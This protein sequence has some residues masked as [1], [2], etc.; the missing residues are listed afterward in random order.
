MEQF[1]LRGAC[2]SYLVTTFL[3]TFATVSGYAEGGINSWIKP[4]S[5]NWDDPAG[6]SQGAL[7]NSSQ[8][9]LITNSGWKAVAINPSTPTDSRTV[10]SIGIAGAWDTRN[11]LL[12]NYFGTDY[13]LTVLNGLTLQ[14]NAQIVNFNSGLIVQGGTITITNSQ[15]IQD[16][17]F[18][19]TTNSTMY[20]Q[21]AEYDLTNGVFEGGQVLLGFPVS[22][23]FNQYGGTAVITNL[24]FGQGSAYAGGH[25]ALYGGELFLPNGLRLLGGNNAY[26]SYFQAG[27]T[28]RTTSVY[29]EP[30]LLGSVPGFTLNGGLLS[31]QDVNMVGDDFGAIYIEQ[32]G[33]THSVSNALNI[34][35]GTSH[36]LPRPSAYHLNGGTLSVNLLNLD[37]HPGDAWFIQSNGTTVAQKVLANA[38][39]DWAYA[40]D[41]LLSGGTLT[42][43][44]LVASSGVNNIHQYGGSLVVSDTLAWSGSRDRSNGQFP[45]VYGGYSF[46]GGTL[47]ASNISIGANL[48]IGDSSGSPRISN[49][50]TFTL[51][52][53]L[54]ISNAVEQLGRFVLGGNSIIDLA[55]NA[56]RLSFAN[57]SSETWAQGATLVVSNWNG[58][59]GGGGPE[60]LKFGSNQSGLTPAQLS[61]I[62]FRAGYPPDFYSAKILSTGE[63]VPDHVIAPSV[64]SARQGN[65]LVLSWPA[66]WVLQSATNAP[67]PYSDV[68]GATSPYSFDMTSAP[69]QFFRLRWTLQGP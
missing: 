53:V 43:S 68:P 4:G 33:G 61:H 48:V 11:V 3:F 2:L 14:D 16:G 22:A 25:Y 21:R 12:L 36:G 54:Q 30:N 44:N 7:P 64:T 26:S 46:L 50:G 67:G 20:L 9:V 35:G 52:H 63:V 65:N 59:L 8:S 5:G 10:G 31:D 24:G 28:N 56:S 37:G 58:N 15:I 51:Y 6:W 40:T 62:R 19:S 45:P 23:Q 13:P 49:P 27:G 60:Q 47:S 66:G 55:G 29:L 57:S 1:K 32:N 38:P 42:C 34:A 39:S 41:L 69:Q 17:G 18:I